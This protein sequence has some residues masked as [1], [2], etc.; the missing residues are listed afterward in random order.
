MSAQLL[1][2][3]TILQQLVGEHGKL[4]KHIDRHQSAM[5]ALDLVAMDEAARQQEACRIR[6]GG[7][8]NRRRVLVS[9]IAAQLRMD[10]HP[11]VARVSAAAPPILRAK[12]LTLRQELVDVMEAI[13]KRVT[14]A[15]RLAGALL[16][17][18]NTAVRLLS[19]AVEQAGTYTK[20]GVPRVSA[21]IGV[22]EA[23]G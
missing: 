14:V 19:G 6:I 3:E 18:L 7:I 8:E 13:S 12:L 10:G 2:L 1:Q 22:M 16:G 9:Q 17:H 5:K 21:R 20:H 11:T 15:G 4:L 23:V